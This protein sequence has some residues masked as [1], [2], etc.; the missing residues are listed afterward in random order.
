MIPRN[1]EV[2][3]H[4]PIYKRIIVG[5]ADA[6]PRTGEWPPHVR[7]D[8]EECERIWAAVKQCAEGTNA[9]VPVPDVLDEPT[10]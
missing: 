4:R 5:Q 1:A 2:G 7:L 3:E 10:I 8:L 6:K 9:T